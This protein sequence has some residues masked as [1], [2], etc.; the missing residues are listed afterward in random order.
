M[1]ARQ[2]ADVT[3]RQALALIEAAARA[4]QVCPSGTEL[5]QHLGHLASAYANSLLRRAETQGLIVIAAQ[6]TVRRIVAA[7]DGS[8][9]TAVPPGWV[10]DAPAPSPRAKRHDAGDRGVGIQDPEV[11][12]AAAVVGEAWRNLTAQ[13]VAGNSAYSTCVT[14]EEA[15]DA[16]RFCTDPRGPWAE[17]RAAWCLAAG[18]DPDAFRDRALARLNAAGPAGPKGSA[19]GHV[20]AEASGQPARRVASGVSS[21]NSAGRGQPRPAT[22]SGVPA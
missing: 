15:R 14:P 22:F 9:R 17:A 1:T 4:G 3:M 21:R 16:R 5:A 12:L 18:I 20:P 2:D 11:S 10:A 13:I 6:G 8:W 19:G 7:A